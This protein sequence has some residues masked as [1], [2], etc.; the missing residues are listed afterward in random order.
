MDETAISC[1]MPNNVTVHKIDYKTMIIKTKRQEKLR[2]SVILSIFCDG[3]RLKSYAKF[4]G[5]KNGKIYNSLSKLEI[6]KNK[7]FIINV[8][9]NAWSII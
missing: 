1:N 2:V 9:K 7:N 4:K 3:R 6:V 8:N 5:A